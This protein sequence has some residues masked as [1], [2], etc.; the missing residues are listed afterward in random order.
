MAPIQ[1]LAQE[2][3]YAAGTAL[4]KKKKKCIEKWCR[5]GREGRSYL[6]FCPPP[7]SLPSRA[8]LLTSPWQTLVQGKRF[9]AL[10]VK[11]PLGAGLAEEQ[12]NSSFSQGPRGSGG[13][14]QLITELFPGRI[15]RRADR[16]PL[17]HFLEEAA[18]MLRKGGSLTGGRVAKL[19]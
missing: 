4:N 13:T 10:E 2:L 14:G 8:C 17:E 12:L 7:P 18:L 9:L 5:N 15:R 11:K 16:V 6:L 1:P 3:S 19:K